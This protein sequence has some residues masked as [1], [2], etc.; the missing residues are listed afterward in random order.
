MDIEFDAGKRSKTLMERG[1]DFAHANEIFAG[2]HFTAEDA[3]ENYS[4]LR[5]ITAGKLNDR[6]VI[7][8]WTPRGKT[9]RIISMRKANE[10]E[11]KRY[12]ER[13]D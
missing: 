7:I 2:R 8:V 4:E 12:S 6:M 1:L 10:R 13:L 5:Y 9:R 11:R 3:H